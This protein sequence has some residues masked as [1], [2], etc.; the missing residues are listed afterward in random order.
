MIKL[1]EY[2]YWTKAKFLYFSELN[3]MKMERMKRYTSLELKDGRIYQVRETPQE[4]L[5]IIENEKSEEGG[6]E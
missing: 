5:T 6:E 3:I 1:T 2:R 4:I